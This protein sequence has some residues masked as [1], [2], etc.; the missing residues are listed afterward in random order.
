MDLLT[1]G[2]GKTMKHFVILGLI[3]I[4]LS[5]CAAGVALP[6][7]NQQGRAGVSDWEIS[8][9]PETGN[10]EDVRIIDGKEKADVNFK[11]DLKSGT[12]EYSAKDVDAFEGQKARAAVEQA[13]YENGIPILPGLVDSIVKAISP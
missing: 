2:E 4:M 1:T 5:G 8:F 6:S 9:N 10:V 7:S 11:V 12:A 13:L 3:G